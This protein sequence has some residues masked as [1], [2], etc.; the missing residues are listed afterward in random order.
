MSIF[1]FIL[2]TAFSFTCFT[3]AVGQQE[4]NP[5]SICIMHVVV[6]GLFGITFTTMFAPLTAEI[7][8]IA[9]Q[10]VPGLGAGMGSSLDPNIISRASLGSADSTE[11]TM[12]IMFSSWPRRSY[13]TTGC[14][15]PFNGAHVKAVEGGTP[16][17]SGGI[18][19]ARLHGIG[20]A[21]SSDYLEKWGLGRCTD[22]Q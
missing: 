3:R 9:P 1:P 10:I 18:F 11:A 22:S 6:T 2:A 16:G 8:R 7:E 17:N 12:A 5:L 21:T 19:G 14:P 20:R 15:S 4:G 13:S